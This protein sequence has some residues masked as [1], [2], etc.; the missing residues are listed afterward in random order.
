MRRR[1]SQCPASSRSAIMRGV[2]NESKR[3]LTRMVLTVG[4]TGQLRRIKVD[5]PQIA[6]TVALRLIVEVFRRHSAGFT[7]GRYRLRT[8][9]VTELD[10][11]DEAVAGVAVHLLRAFVGS[12]AERRERSQAGRGEAD[13]K[14]RARV[15]EWLHDVA[16]QTLEAVDV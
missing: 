2:E 13:R 11:G 9:L 4:V 8:H 7:A 6:G 3:L 1:S 10:D 16:G 5:I 14:A 12:R 15:V